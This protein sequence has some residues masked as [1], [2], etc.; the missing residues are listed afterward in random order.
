LKNLLIR[1]LPPKKLEINEKYFAKIDQTLSGIFIGS[2]YTSIVGGVVAVI[3]F[4]LFNIPRPLATACLV[5]LAGLVPFLTWLVFIPI[6]IYRYFEYGAFDA[7]IFLDSINSGPS[8]RI[9]HK[10]ILCIS[11]IVSSPLVSHVDFY[12]RWPS[13]RYCRIFPSSGAHWNC[14]CNLPGKTR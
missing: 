4:Y 7:L 2:I 1:V 6:S 11:Q 5:I 14:I 12:R 13:R 3:I 10:T 9:F 8:C